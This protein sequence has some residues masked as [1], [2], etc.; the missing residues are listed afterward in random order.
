MNQGCY[1]NQIE[2]NELSGAD[3][4]LEFYFRQADWE[5]VRRYIRKYQPD[6]Y[7]HQ[8]AECELAFEKLKELSR[9]VNY[10]PYENKGGFLA[11]H[12]SYVSDDTILH[13]EEFFI[14][15][16]QC[17]VLDLRRHE[18]WM[19]FPSTPPEYY[20]ANCLVNMIDNQQEIKMRYKQP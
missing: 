16:K 4:R 6:C 17:T 3:M 19:E 1:C 7:D 5:K 18:P 20:V 13:Q 15:S 11:V 9:K 12:D 8:L 14:E 10:N 2:N